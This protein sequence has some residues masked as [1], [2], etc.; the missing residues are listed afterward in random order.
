MSQKGKFDDILKKLDE[1]IKSGEFQKY[2]HK[3]LEKE[4]KNKEHI[5]DKE[6]FIWL[7]E[8]VQKMS[9]MD[10]VYGTEDFL[11]I[12]KSLFTEQDIENEKYIGTPIFDLFDEIGA[13]QGLS[14]TED[15]SW[16][17]PS[18]EW[19]FKFQG[20]MYFICELIGQGTEFIVRKESN[21]AKKYLDLDLWF[22]KN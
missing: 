10:R 14:V 15:H 7:A 16:S 6:Y 17:F 3:L 20:K 19:I 13:E 2:L 4:K 18:F 9:N 11:Y 8:F 21:K 5:N 22:E 12:D 1:D